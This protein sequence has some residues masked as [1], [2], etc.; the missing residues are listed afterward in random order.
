MRTDELARLLASDLW[1]VLP[2]ALARVQAAALEH[3]DGPLAAVPAVQARRAGTVAV[4]PVRGLISHHP[5]LLSLFGLGAS[6]ERLAGMVRAAVSDP[7]VSAV[8]LDIDS[9]GGTVGGIEEAASAIYAL[10]GRKPTVAVANSLMASAAYWLG[11]AADEVV[12]TPSGEVGSIGVFAAHVDLSRALDQAGV[13]VSLVSAGR[14]K[15]EGNEFEPLSDEARAAIQARVDDYYGLFTRAVAR[16]RGVSVETVRNGFGE[17]R[18]VGAREAVRLGMADRVATLDE[19]LQRLGGR[20]RVATTLAAREGTAEL[21]AGPIAPHRSPRIADEDA[22]WDADRELARA[23]GRE[24]LRR[25]HAWV[26]DEGDPDAKS[27]YKLPHHRADGTLVP[28]GLFAAAA[29]LQGGRGGVELPRDDVPGVR[30]HLG[31]HYR[32]L[33]RE[34][35]WEQEAAALRRLRLLG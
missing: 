15:T 21:A 29:A 25:M 3:D 12:V 19:T 28:R 35:P 24:E 30:R 1:A 5:T 32:E 31:G 33:D 23:E 13:R 4:V 26:D 22:E 8:V 10:R 18:V 9:P 17:G 7:D 20:A 27:S 14:Y 6:A 16:N 11:T 34:P 2:G